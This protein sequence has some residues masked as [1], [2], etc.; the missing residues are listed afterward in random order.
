MGD[1]RTRLLALTV[2]YG[3]LLIAATLGMSWF[4][5]RSAEG[6]LG[7][8]LRS[9]EACSAEGPCASISL[10]GL[11]GSYATVGPMV[12]WASL[13][14][15]L[16]VLVQAA[17]RW[18]GGTVHAGAARAATLASVGLVLLAFLAGY[19]VDP[20]AGAPVMAMLGMAFER[21][22]APLLLIAAHALGPVVLHLAAA[23]ELPD[24]PPVTATAPPPGSAP[25]A[26]LAAEP[27]KPRVVPPIELP[28]EDPSLDGPGGR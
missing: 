20:D 28:P 18:M 15:G 26:T 14:T 13:A 7:I 22:W 24:Y 5:L 8:G 11:P 9:F 25:R 27:P 12:F 16:V 21:T 2:V 6:V 23:E 4:E 10:D 3:G 1:A 19:V 17:L